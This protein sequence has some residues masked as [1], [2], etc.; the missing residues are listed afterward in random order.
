MKTAIIPALAAMVLLGCT[1]EDTEELAR[2]REEAAHL[3]VMVAPPPASLDSLYPP[4]APAPLFLQ[5]MLGLGEAFT[6]LAVDVFEQ[7]AEHVATGLQHFRAEYE[8]VSRLVPEWQ[9][10]YPTGP[11]DEL[12]AALE[13]G[14][15]ERIGAAFDGVG[16]VC[17]RCH[18][19]DMAKVHFR[20][21]WADF[22][23]LRLTDRTT[24]R[25]LSYRQLMREMEAAFVG[26]GVDLR[27]EQ[28]ENARGQF[29]TFQ[30]RF[31]LLATVCVACHTTERAYFVDARIQEA[32][33][34]LG[35]VLRD[36]APDPDLAA[37]LSQRIGME[38]CSKCHLVHGPAALTK[39]LWEEGLHEP[40]T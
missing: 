31:G 16:A 12:A 15:P 6:G 25:E 28:V 32:I 36:E 5:R 11:L 3:R 2:L 8:A 17:H 22:S 10:A 37:E 29:D 18:V 19:T 20:Y 35:D 33:R 30:A 34:R 39:A 40:G 26:I 38:S 24:G 23:T 14:D 1:R 7:D 27:Q 21:R 4:L 9:D 13:A